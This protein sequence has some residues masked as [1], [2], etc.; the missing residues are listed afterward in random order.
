MDYELGLSKVNYQTV[1]LSKGVW[2]TQTYTVHE[3]F[4]I[5][6]DAIEYFQFRFDLS[7]Y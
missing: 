1:N 4:K 3:Y 5:F 6:Q 7:L 2:I